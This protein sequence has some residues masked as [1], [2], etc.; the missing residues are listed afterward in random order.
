MDKPRPTEQHRRLEEF[1][2]QW[3]GKERISQPSSYTTRSEATGTFDFYM[4]VGGFFLVGDYVEEAD[5]ERLLAGHLLW[6][7]DA[8]NKCYTMH[9]FDTYGS[10]PDRPGRGQWE[11]DTLAFEHDLPSHKGRT[12]FTLGGGE[13]G[14][15]V[16]MNVGGQGWKTAVEGTYARS[17]GTFGS[18]ERRSTAARP[19][20]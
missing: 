18:A 13:L 14:F 7:W 9:W 19:H 11:G 12:V 20:H 17:L 2:G 16:E 5:G 8:K 1:A 10:P 3:V 6:G 15:R 4:D